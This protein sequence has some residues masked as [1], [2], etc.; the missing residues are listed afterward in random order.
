MIF[1]QMDR[2]VELSTLHS[3]FVLIND[4]ILLWDGQELY[5]LS[6]SKPSEKYTKAQRINIV[7]YE[8]SRRS[9][10]NE[11]YKD[12]TYQQIVKHRRIYLKINDK[13]YD[14]FGQ[15]EIM[16]DNDYID[17]IEIINLYY[18]ER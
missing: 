3:E 17:P 8:Y 18:E 7:D 15:I 12:C 16:S 10:K 1:I 6:G 9:S 4:C 5:Y 13:W 14:E 2:S 11:K